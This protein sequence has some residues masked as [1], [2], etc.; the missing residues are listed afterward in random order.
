MPRSAGTDRLV[1][2]EDEELL[3]R[4]APP[5][6]RMTEMP[7]QLRRRLVV[8]ARRDAVA[9]QRVRSVRLD[10]VVDQPPDAALVNDLVEVVLLDARAQVGAGAGEV[11]DLDD[12]VIHVRD[13]HGAVGGS[14]DIDGTEQR[15]ERLDELV[16]RIRVVQVGEAF[17]LVRTDAA[18]DAADRLAVQIIADEIL[19][20]AV[21]PIDVVAGAAGDA[22][23]RAIGHARGVQ[24]AL[25]VGNAYRCAPGNPEVRL[26][27]V[28]DGEVAV[29][30]RELEADRHAGRA[31]LEPH[32]AV[33]V[34]RD[35]P[36]AA[37][38]A[39]RLL[40][41]AVRCPARAERVVGAVHPVV[42]APGQE[43]LLPF[44][45]G[46]APVPGV[47][48]LLLV[49]DA[50]AVRIGVLPQL[51]RV[52]LFRQDG[53]GSEWR[54]EPREHEVVD[55]DGVLVVDA[56]VV[57][58]DM[59]RDP[60]DRI[61]LAR[62]VDIEHVAAILDD[63]HAAVAVEG[64]G[65]RLLDEGIGH[66]QLETIAGWQD[67]LLQLLFGR[68]RLDRRLL[69][70]VDPGQVLTAAAASPALGAALSRRTWYGWSARRR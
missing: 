25:H 37:V 3:R 8:H 7:D 27:L 32:L 29:D 5:A 6:V 2:L 11:P 46:E 44:D 30:D 36:L 12:A 33:V 53:V 63:E 56:V 15:V 31:A 50:V 58:V 1:L 4:V 65:R 38:V 68:L 24:A 47:E 42:E 21:A 61:E 45:V 43:R 64:D 54:H 18:D 14:R 66:H 41:H 16:V 23:E 9:A 62:H 26:E 39:G 35:A 52:R 40:H 55:E 48:Q 67:E 69:G 59:Q 17:L 60:A 57:G 34:L 28:G 70:E 19:R 22:F 49:R 20:Q 10:A 13:V 51:L